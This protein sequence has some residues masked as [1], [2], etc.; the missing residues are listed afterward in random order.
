M[1]LKQDEGQLEKEIK[2][3]YNHVQELNQ[4]KEAK[5][6]EFIEKSKS[7]K[8]RAQEFLEKRLNYGKET[9]KIFPLSYLFYIVIGLFYTILEEFNWYV[10]CLIAISFAGILV[11]YAKNILSI[12]L[13]L[14]LVFTSLL[15]ISLVQKLKQ[16]LYKENAN[17]S[18][19]SFNLEPSFYMKIFLLGHIFIILNDQFGLWEI[20]I[21]VSLMQIVGIIYLFYRNYKSFYFWCLLLFP[22]YLFGKKIQFNLWIQKYYSLNKESNHLQQI[23]HDLW[24][25]SLFVTSLDSQ[26][27]IQLEFHN[28]KAKEES[29]SEKSIYDYFKKIKFYQL[30]DDA[31]DMSLGTYS[32]KDNLLKLLITKLSKFDQ[33]ATSN[34]NLQITN[35]IQS[36]KSNQTAANLN[37]S[38]IYKDQNKRVSASK[39]AHFKSTKLIPQVSSITPKKQ[40]HSS[41]SKNITFE[42]VNNNFKEGEFDPNKRK[43]TNLWSDNAFQL[44]HTQADYEDGFSYKKVDKYFGKY[45]S[46][47]EDPQKYKSLTIKIYYY[48]KNEDK[49]KYQFRSISAI[50]SYLI[51]EQRQKYLFIEIKSLDE[52][53]KIKKGDCINNKFN[54]NHKQS[55][56]S[57]LLKISKNLLKDINQHFQQIVNPYKQLVELMTSQQY[58]YNSNFMNM[59]IQ[60]LQ[61]LYASNYEYQAKQIQQQMDV[62]EN[63]SFPYHLEYIQCQINTFIDH[64]RI[65]LNK[66]TKLRVEEINMQILFLD[67]FKNIQ[68]SRYKNIDYSLEMDPTTFPQKYKQDPGRIKQI[69]HF[70]FRKL[71]INH[72]CINPKFVMKVSYLKKRTESLQNPQTLAFMDSRASNAHSD[73]FRTSIIQH[74]KSTLKQISNLY[75]TNNCFVIELILKGHCNFE[76]IIQKQNLKD[77]DKLFKTIQKIGQ[78]LGQ[79]HI[80]FQTQKDC[81][82]R[83][84]LFHLKEV[85]PK[86]QLNIEDKQAPSQ[87]QKEN[88]I[89]HNDE[90]ANFQLKMKTD[91]KINRTPISNNNNNNNNLEKI[92][93]QITSN[94]SLNTHFL[95]KDTILNT[96]TNQ[97]NRLLFSQ[98][99]VFQ[100]LDN[101][102]QDQSQQSLQEMMNVLNGEQQVIVNQPIEFKSKFM[103]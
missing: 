48:S 16:D 30:K 45:I 76:N 57:G 72:D 35:P 7:L 54:E 71:V 12:K 80:E 10:I 39:I 36:Q 41:L 21:I 26:N 19:L 101:N 78:W 31:S 85:N 15:L 40:Q 94:H 27:Q 52:D 102:F 96:P 74:R 61:T 58:C 81:L 49:S 62:I 2:Q 69:L 63:N 56:K 66:K 43:S 79:T 100:I 18:D 88:P 47:L 13:I 46:S 24:P 92:I 20:D 60:Q 14:R 23:F 1:S 22:L 11:H 83:K 5:C 98:T 34:I 37:P 55:D 89:N 86:Q 6:K 87:N 67:F 53:E 65:H 84:Y 73:Q 9:I 91:S 93:S 75:S 28:R 32:K 64:V 8:K 51:N 3:N 33:Q 68:E 103:K 17:P 99:N 95:K 4:R 50:N 90:E 59:Q 29:A 42:N 44:K 25:H 70:L 38:N 77:K 97:Q 82:Q